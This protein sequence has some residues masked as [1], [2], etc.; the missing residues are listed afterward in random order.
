MLDFIKEKKDCWEFLASSDIPIFIYG[1]GDGAIKI[2]SSMKKYGIAVSGFFASDEFVRGHYFEQHKV[3]S[4]SEIENFLDDFIIVLAFAAGYESL[5]NR[6]E[7]LSHRHTLVAPDVPVAGDG[8]FTYQYCLENAE[9]L[10]KVYSMLEDEQ[11]R[12]VFADVINFKISGKINYLISSATPKSE[13]FQNIIKTFPGEIYLDLGAYDGDTVLE[14]SSICP[15]YK[16]IIALEPDRKNFRKLTKNTQN[17]R[18]TSLINSAVWECDTLIPFSSKAGRQSSVSKSGEKIHARSVD[19]ILNDG[20]CS[21]IKMD[22]EGCEKMALFGAK[23]T[24]KKYSPKLMVSLYHRNED[25][26]ELPLL[27]KELNPN[28]K[29]FIRRQPYIPAWETNLYAII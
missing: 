5:I 23:Q 6:I 10:E 8:L 11:S 4:L 19:S 9:K 13:V 15:E 12:R 17:M 3:H 16:K 25:I 28:Y 14:F 1:M 26:F 22:V 18:D 27:I 20:P 24:I 2:M 7:N 29:L 21:T